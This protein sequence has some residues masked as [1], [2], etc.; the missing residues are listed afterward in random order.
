MGDRSE[1]SVKL[2][3]TWDVQPGREPEYFEFMSREFIPGMQKLGIRPTEAWY[4]YFGS[5]PQMLT[6]V[7]ADS[8]PV[9]NR[10]LA[11]EDWNK[12]RERLLS[13]VMNFHSRIVKA[14][15]GFQM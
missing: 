14:S 5:R 7:L 8:V 6:A 2:L 11:T 10:A 15:A 13:Y 1:K 4:T 3:M 9:M 12:L